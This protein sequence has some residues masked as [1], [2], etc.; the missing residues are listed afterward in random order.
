MFGHFTVNS[1]YHSIAVA[2]ISFY[3]YIF[4]EYEFAIFYAW[5]LIFLA[6]LWLTVNSVETQLTAS[7]SERIT[8][9]G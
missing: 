9:A 1:S 2:R 8:K 5:R 3:G 6:V 7:S 4:Y